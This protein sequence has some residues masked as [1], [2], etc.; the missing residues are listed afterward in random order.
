MKDEIQTKVKVERHF[1][2]ATHFP[3]AFP[4][5]RVCVKFSFQEVLVLPFHFDNMICSPSSS[6]AANTF[7]PSLFIMARVIK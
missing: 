6:P 2:L 7:L 3:L 5:V 1:L 4:D